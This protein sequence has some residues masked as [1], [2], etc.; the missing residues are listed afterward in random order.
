MD[1]K[2][3]RK[4]NLVALLEKSKKNQRE[5]AEFV[6]T[7]AAYI[8]QLLS[9]K[10]KRDMGDELARKIEVAFALCHGGMDHLIAQQGKSAYR[11]EL[12][13]AGRRVP[14][15]SWVQAGQWS[16]VVDNFAPGDAD[17][18]IDCPVPCSQETFCLRVRGASM[19]PRFHDGE[20]IYVDP[21]AEA[22]NKSFIIVRLDDEQQATFKQLIIEGEHRYLKPFNPNWPDPIIEINGNATICGVVIFKGER[23]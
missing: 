8:S 3:I 21:K 20:Y 15:I 18:W 1:S 11:F 2:E 14:V 22:R 6:G 10:I 19:E 9:D 17:D 12:V 23:V 4:L 16:D 13:P 7:D 5:F